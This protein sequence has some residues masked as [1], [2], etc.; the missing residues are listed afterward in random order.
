[1]ISHS[2][3]SKSRLWPTET[4]TWYIFNV[5]VLIFHVVS[6]IYH[7]FHSKSLFSC[8]YGNYKG[9]VCWQKYSENFFYNFVLL[10][11]QNFIAYSYRWDIALQL[12]CSFRIPTN[13]SL[14]IFCFKLSQFLALAKIRLRS[15]SEGSFS[16]LPKTF[17]CLEWVFVQICNVFFGRQIVK[18]VPKNGRW[19]PSQSGKTKMVVLQLKYES[20]WA[21]SYI[22]VNHLYRPFFSD[23]VWRIS[24]F[25]VQTTIVDIYGGPLLNCWI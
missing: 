3:S 19:K 22:Y 16:T 10:T 2:K 6:G 9:G 25:L 23:K 17:A 20:N 14:A 12:G 18:R 13:V 15:N 4:I 21:E 1:M 11:A 5:Q 24:F 8:C 7:Y